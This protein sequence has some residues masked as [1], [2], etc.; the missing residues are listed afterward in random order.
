MTRPVDWLLAYWAV[1]VPACIGVMAYETRKV[2]ARRRTEKHPAVDTRELPVFTDNEIVAALCVVG[3]L[4][5][6]QVDGFSASD[7]DVQALALRCRIVFG[8]T[9]T[10][11]GHVTRP[12]D[13]RIVH[14]DVIHD[15]VEGG[16]S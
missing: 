4:A 14:P 10:D 7:F 16:R 13:I 3:A 6:H 8:R 15:S 5:D 9:L 11:T 1:V 2:I 12:R